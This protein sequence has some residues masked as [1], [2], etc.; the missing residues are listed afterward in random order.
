MYD[1]LDYEIKRLKSFLIVGKSVQELE[2]NDDYLIHKGY[3]SFS[4]NPCKDGMLELTGDGVK[5]L[6]E[7]GRAESIAEYE[8]KKHRKPAAIILF[9][10]PDGFEA[11]LGRVTKKFCDLEAAQKWA[12]SKNLK[13]MGRGL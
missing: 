1:L 7:L 4:N 6:F 10:T 3:L 13:I 9:R 8:H 5:A 2:S 11:L 12:Q